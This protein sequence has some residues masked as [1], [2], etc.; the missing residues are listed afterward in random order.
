VVDVLHGERFCDQS[1]EEVY[2]TLLDEGRYLCSA[3][4]M[5]RLPRQ[6]GETRE[7]RRQAAHPA[8]RK[9]ELVAVGPN[10]VWTWDITKL[11]GPGRWQ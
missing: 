8:L 10:Q 9:P 2:H 11:A 1:V 4:T 3:T 5:Y 7:R 6:A